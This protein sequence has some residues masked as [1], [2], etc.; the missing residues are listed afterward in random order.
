[1]PRSATIEM[2]LRVLIPPKKKKKGMDG[3]LAQLISLYP[4]TNADLVR[5]VFAAC[6]NDVNR[7]KAAL[8]E[9]TDNADEPVMMTQRRQPTPI[10]SPIHA[11][12]PRKRKNST[13]HKILLCSLAGDCEGLKECLRSHASPNV[14]DEGM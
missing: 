9:I 4:S 6:D 2:S 13:Q 12:A 5:D 10:I 7:A 1:V 14:T 11:H 3:G 8:R